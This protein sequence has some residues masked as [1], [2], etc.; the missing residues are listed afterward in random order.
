MEMEPEPTSAEAVAAVAAALDT[1][2]AV[3]VTPA[4][5]ADARRL[6]TDVEAV[7]RRGKLP[8]QGGSHRIYPRGGG[9]G[10]AESGQYTRD[11]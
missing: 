8:P 3:G 4:D 2:Q 10:S 6:I 11:K 9:I 5:A 7:A 1:L